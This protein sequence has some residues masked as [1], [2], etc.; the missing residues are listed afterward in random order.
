MDTLSPKERSE[1]MARV[2]GRNT[3]PERTVRSVLFSLGYR[4]RLHGADVPGRPDIVLRSRRCVILVHGCFWHRHACPNGRRMPKSRV[5]F[6]R[7]KLDG[8]AAR[9]KRTRARLRRD[10]WR[11]LVVWECQLRDLDKLAARLR[12]FLDPAQAE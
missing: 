10:G 11:V 7:A 4:F 3:D 8:N 5:A 6:W 12:A 1:R 2:R 9:D